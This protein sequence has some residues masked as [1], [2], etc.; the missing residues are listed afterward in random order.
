[1]PSLSR[2]LRRLLERTI[3]GADGAR[4]IAEAG[5]EQSLQRLA[6]I[7]MSRTAP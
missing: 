3:A 5:A 2:E 4:Q 7:V 6:E 1:M